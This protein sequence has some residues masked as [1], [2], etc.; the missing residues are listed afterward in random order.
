ME[1]GF[2]ILLPYY[3]YKDSK[4]HQNLKVN[5]VCL[6]KCETRVTSTYRLCW[7]TKLLHSDDDIVRTMEVQLQNKRLSKRNQLIKDLVTAVQRLMLLVPADELE[8]GPPEP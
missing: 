1:Q 4:C 5:D 3:K 7:V 6:I 2:P 8:Q